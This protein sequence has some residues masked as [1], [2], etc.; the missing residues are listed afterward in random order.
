MR[1]MIIFHMFTKNDLLSNNKLT[2]FF[3]NKITRNFKI[4]RFYGDKF[5]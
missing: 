2:F 4:L 1:F 3:I 5:Y